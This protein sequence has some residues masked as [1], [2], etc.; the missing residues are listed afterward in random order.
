MI[1]GVSA[2]LFSVPLRRA[3]STDTEDHEDPT[4][5]GETEPPAAPTPREPEPSPSGRKGTPRVTVTQEDSEG[6]VSRAGSCSQTQTVVAID[7]LA[8]GPFGN[9]FLYS[10]KKTALHGPTSFFVSNHNMSRQDSR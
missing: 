6:V 5:P 1:S 7:L 4:A 2:T 8:L 3:I 9:I 10:K